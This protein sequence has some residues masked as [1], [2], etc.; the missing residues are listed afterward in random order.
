MASLLFRMHGN[1]CT[2]HPWEVIVATLTLTACMM[3]VDYQYQTPP[4]KPTI[5]SCGDCI[6]EV[7]KF[8]NFQDEKR[9]FNLNLE[10]TKIDLS[11][12]NV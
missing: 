4:P 7:R 8:L 11:Q 2:S 1:F 3:T 12:G 5:R 10:S 9:F 6:E